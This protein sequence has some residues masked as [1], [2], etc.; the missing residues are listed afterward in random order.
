MTV[1]VSDY[2]AQYLQDLGVRSVFLLSG[3]GMMHLLD[4][5]SRMPQIRYFC[6]HH[7]QA[8]AMAAEG[9]ARQTGELGVCYATSGPGGTNTL[10][11]I[12]GAYQDSSPMIVFTGQSK[13]S[14]TIQMSGI[15]GL[16]QFGVFEVDIVPIVQSV[17]K[18]AIFLDDP[19]MVRYHL[20][21]AVQLALSGRPGPVLIDVPL[22]VQAAP[23]DP[24]SLRPY[25]GPLVQNPVPSSEVVAE[26]LQRLKS[27]R[28]PLLLVGHGLR[29]SN[30]VEAFREVIHRLNVPVV[31][32]SL[33]LDALPYDDSLFIGHPGPKGDRAGNFAIQTAD[34]I[35]S[36]GSSLH[37]STTGYEL[38]QFAVQAYKV[39]VDLDE[40]VL[41]REQ[42]GVNQKILSGAAEFLSA[43]SEHLPADPLRV[44][45][46]PWLAKCRDWKERYAVKNETHIPNPGKINYYDLIALLGDL[47]QGDETLVTDA[48]S[49]Y[50]V[51][52]QGFRVKKQQRVIV[53]GALGSMG[54]ALPASIGVASADPERTV[55]C[56][57]GDGSLQT[58]IQELQTLR[59]YGL[60][61]KLLVVSNDGY[62]SIR[63]TQ[64]SFFDGHL[65]GASR[66]S[67]VSTPPLD[68]IAAAYGL[69]YLRCTHEDEVQPALQRMLDTPGPMVCEVFTREDQQILPTVSS[70]RMA[71]GSMKSQPLHNMF[72]FLEEA[73][74]TAEMEE[75]L[76]L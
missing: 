50:Y 22:D 74:L 70:K 8:S 28:R 14:Q 30:A 76:N 12:V 6:N 20:E 57:T 23:I 19:Q 51:T 73:A 25:D 11:G 58:N 49:A 53:S 21:H 3:G 9:Y 46:D 35:L 48:G 38:D 5:V 71:D 29:V 37:V 64:S 15:V 41:S 75:A 18:A 32:T 1:R 42:I 68:K 55:V 69:T 34:V 7:E 52:G 27:A 40:A 56:L 67:G 4:A 44:S 60:N 66:D 24:D 47:M 16:R 39:Q 61:I 33:A 63:N 45:S 43:V 17:T 59:H 65:A 13:R 31:T 72:P 26:V 2:I 36:L 62:Q 54:Y 10:T